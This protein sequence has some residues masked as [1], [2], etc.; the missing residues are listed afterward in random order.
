MRGALLETNC[1]YG[2]THSGIGVS[3]GWA[4]F[5]FDLFGALSSQ[6]PGLSEFFGSTCV[7]P[8]CNFNRYR[9][10]LDEKLDLRQIIENNAVVNVIFDRDAVRAAFAQPDSDGRFSPDFFAYLNELGLRRSSVVLAF[11]PKAA[12][13]YLRTAAIEVAD[14]QLVRTVHAQGGRDASFYLPVLLNYFA[15]DFPAKTLVTHVHMQAFPANISL[16]EALD[17]K[18][19][20]MLRSIPDMLASYWDMLDADHLSP[21][22]GLNQRIPTHFGGMSDKE[23]GDF[24]IDMI[25]PWYVSYFATWISYSND[26]PGRV[27]ELTFDEFRT[28]PAASLEKVMAHSRISR[29][30]N[31]CQRAL[32][33]TWVDRGDLRFNKGVSGRGGARFTA[34]QMER[35]LEQISFYPELC[36][37][38]GVLFPASPRDKKENRS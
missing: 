18:P 5:Y 28:D 10:Q 6:Y 13:T 33:T 25:G 14:G 7:T 21:N 8:N 38:K 19:V 37:Q 16:I 2:N 4:I 26:T 15:G 1:L 23:K 36:D 32:D 17:L 3:A 20:I 35:L 29:S 12:G 24:L 27:L 11:A 31:D 9:A 34:S 22:M 30:R